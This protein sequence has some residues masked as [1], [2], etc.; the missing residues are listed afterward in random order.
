MM[1]AASIF[2]TSVNVYETTSCYVPEDGYLRISRRE[3]VESHHDCIIFELR[4]VLSSL[5]SCFNMPK[6]SC[7][8]NLY[9]DLVHRSLCAGDRLGFLINV[10]QL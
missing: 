10:L 6:I 5:V 8:Q 3:K 4:V 2:E 1:E 9:L 7:R